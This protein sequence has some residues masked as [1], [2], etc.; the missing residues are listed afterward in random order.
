VKRWMIQTLNPRILQK[1]KEIDAHN[2]VKE[3]LRE[4]LYFELE[5]YYKKSKYGKIYDMAIKKYGLK[6]GESINDH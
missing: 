1:L 6:Y 2:L 5:N 4:M 3:F